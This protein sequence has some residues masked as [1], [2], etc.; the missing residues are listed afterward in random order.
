LRPIQRNC[1]RRMKSGIDIKNLR[2]ATTKNKAK[3]R[4]LILKINLKFIE[5]VYD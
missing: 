2:P 3:T 4:T 1:F 5:S